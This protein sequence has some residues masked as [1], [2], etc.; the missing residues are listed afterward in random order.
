MPQFLFIVE[1]PPSE[2]VSSSPGYPYD[3]IEFANAA[4]EI[5][6][7]FS[8]TR[9]LQLNAWLLTAENSWP[10]MVELSALSIRH[11]LSYS[12]L[13]LERVIDLSSN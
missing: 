1:V 5:L 10:A 12:V 3:W 9:K 2:A 6:K 11:K 8:G 4:T 7:P 13:L